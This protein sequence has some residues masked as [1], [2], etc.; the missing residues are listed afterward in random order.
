MWF[1]VVR[2]VMLVMY[3]HFYMQCEFTYMKIIASN[4]QI[5]VK[6]R[7]NSL[8]AI[9]VSFYYSNLYQAR[10][11]FFLVSCHCLNDKFISSKSSIFFLVSCHCANGWYHNQHI[12]Q[13][14][15]FFN[16]IENTLLCIYLFSCFSGEFTTRRYS[17]LIYRFY[18]LAVIACVL[19][20]K[21]ACQ[22][23]KL[24]PSLRR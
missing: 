4:I 8:S 19:N 2:L 23:S 16:S 14:E 15:I 12:I 10:A 24:T 9:I 18:I 11:T 5:Y 13:K 22:D 3:S 17:S 6:A 20:T 7:E 1:E 21:Q